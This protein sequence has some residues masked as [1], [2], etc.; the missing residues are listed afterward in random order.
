[1]TSVSPKPTEASPLTNMRLVLGLTARALAVNSR[2][3]S[4]S[5]SSVAPSMT[6]RALSAL[7]YTRF[8]SSLMA[9]LSGILSRVIVATAV[10]LAA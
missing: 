8:V 10:R 5:I 3:I 2:G 9:M 7:T 6:V 1:M 4:L